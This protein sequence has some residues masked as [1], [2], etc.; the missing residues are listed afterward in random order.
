MKKPHKDI[1]TNKMDTTQGH[2]KQQHGEN[3]TQT[4]L[5]QQHEDT[6]QRDLSFINFDA[7]PTPTKKMRTTKQ[8]QNNRATPYATKVR[9]FN[10][11]SSTHKEKYEEQKQKNELE[12]HRRKG[13]ADK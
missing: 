2:L 7:N 13:E 6:T 5:K 12:M 9:Y 3:T 8:Q 11:A 4:H 10:R 1:Y